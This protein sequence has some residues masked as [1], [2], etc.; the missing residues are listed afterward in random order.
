VKQQNADANKKKM[1]GPAFKLNCHPVDCFDGN[2]YQSDK[3]LPPVKDTQKPKEA[4][5]PFKPSSPAKASGGMKA[6][7]FEPY[8]SYSSDPYI[9]N[10][11]KRATGEEK[12]RIFVPPAV[13]KSRPTETIVGLNVIRRINRSNF[14][15]ISSVL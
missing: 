14:K 1:K 8:P 11:A 6:G 4:L 5:K 2:P 7:T 3:P 12:K 9:K 10:P 13:P 15:V